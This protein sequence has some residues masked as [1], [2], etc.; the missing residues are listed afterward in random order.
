MSRGCHFHYYTVSPSPFP[1]FSVVLSENAPNDSLRYYSTESDISISRWHYDI[2]L[3]CPSLTSTS[4]VNSCKC[5][6][7]SPQDAG[8]ILAT[9][10][11]TH[12]IFIIIVLL[13]SPSVASEAHLCLATSTALLFAH[14]RIHIRDK[15]QQ[16][17]GPSLRYPP[18]PSFLSSFT[19]TSLVHWI[20]NSS[21]LTPKH[22]EV[23][24][25]RKTCNLHIHRYSA[26]PS[27]LSYCRATT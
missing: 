2:L 22:M 19:G 27:F 10:R 1:S 11:L 3:P 17:V 4:S 24:S 16:H 14:F 15:E 18:P 5:S 20:I 9:G 26:P 12:V 7:P 6:L 23:T 25:S 8:R 13:P 21:S